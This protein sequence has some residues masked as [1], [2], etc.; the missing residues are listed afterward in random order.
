M[1]MRLIKGFPCQFLVSVG[2]E[3]QAPAPISQSWEE[4]NPRVFSASVESRVYECSLAGLQSEGFQVFSL[5]K[6]T[7]ILH[8]LKVFPLPIILLSN[9]LCHFL[10]FHHSF[11]KTKS[12][13]FFFHSLQY[14]A[15]NTEKM[16]K[17]INLKKFKYILWS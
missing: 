10:S 4:T 13:I 8:S 15:R 1:F 17:V 9:V 7:A 2:D 14:E 6:F 12:L 5:S 11:W 16:D 3:L